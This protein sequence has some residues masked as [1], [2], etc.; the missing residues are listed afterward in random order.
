MAQ[1]GSPDPS[2]EVGAA[3][4]GGR[5]A[6]GTY[7]LNPLGQA[8][9]V[10]PSGSFRVSLADLLS[11]L[12]FIVACAL[13]ATGAGMLWGLG[14]TL[15]AAGCMMAPIAVLIGLSGDR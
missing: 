13:V 5:R 10:E 1:V 12:M 3:L 9:P 8:D 2:R 4:W 6:D 7:P 15:I 11:I 14:G